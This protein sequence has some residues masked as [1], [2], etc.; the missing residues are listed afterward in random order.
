MGIEACFAGHWDVPVAFAQGGEAACRE[1]EAMFDGIV[2]ACVKRAV[3]AATCEGPDPAAARRLTAEKV[4][5]AIGALRTGRC[6]PYQP[7]LPM[8]VTI[9]M[10][11]AQEA[12]RAGKKPNVTRLDERTVECVVERYC[13]VV[14]WVVPA[15]LDMPPLS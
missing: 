15:G 6:R 14:N 7:D 12:E 13:D 4:A 9:H 11:T 3:D 8:T 10:T 5:E 2:T 1:A